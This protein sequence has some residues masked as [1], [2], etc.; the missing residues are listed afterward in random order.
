MRHAIKA[1]AAAREYLR[2]TKIQ[3]EIGIIDYFHVINAE[4]TLMSN[5]LSETQI[6]NERLT[7]T[8]LLIK[9]IGGGWR[10][11]ELSHNRN[12]DIVRLAL[13]KKRKEILYNP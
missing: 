3:Y 13:S 10:V 2:L 6:L 7:A 8:V 12:G 5:E 9:A 11:E 4:Q 1:V